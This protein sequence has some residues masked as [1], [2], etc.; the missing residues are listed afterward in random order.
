MEI[1]GYIKQ[2]LGYNTHMTAKHIKRLDELEGNVKDLALQVKDLKETMDQISSVMTY[3]SAMQLQLSQDI[4]IIY[5]SLKNAFDTDSQE[6]PYGF[7]SLG[8]GNDDDD[9]PLPN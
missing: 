9:D 3:I 5:E 7:P 2:I 4:G 1:I 6:D 8:W